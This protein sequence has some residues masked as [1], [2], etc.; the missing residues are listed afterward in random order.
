MQIIKNIFWKIYKE[1]KLNRH[2]FFITNIK[3]R[4][5]SFELLWIEKFKMINEKLIK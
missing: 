2:K 5:N 1:D 4:N 3:A